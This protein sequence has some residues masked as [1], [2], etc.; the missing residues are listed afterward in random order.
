MRK[1][2]DEIRQC[3]N[4]EET[5]L[6]DINGKFNTLT[7]KETVTDEK[8]VHNGWELEYGTQAVQLLM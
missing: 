5:M 4:E 6:D 7:L 8:L 3:L 2:D 1:G